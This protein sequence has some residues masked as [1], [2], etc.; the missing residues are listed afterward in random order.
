MVCFAPCER[1]SVAGRRRLYHDDN[2]DQ[3]RRR[4]AHRRGA[5]IPR[6]RTKLARPVILGG[7]FV[8]V[9]KSLM[10]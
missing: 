7:L 5:L 8:N 9:G 10:V 3:H 1:D 4:G 6:A 2:G